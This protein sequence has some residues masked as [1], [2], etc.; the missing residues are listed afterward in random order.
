MRGLEP[1]LERG[2]RATLAR[3]ATVEYVEENRIRRATGASDPKFAQQWSLARVQA[4]AAWKLIPGKFFDST[5]RAGRVRV[6]ILDSGGDSADAAF[7]GQIRFS[8]SRALV[9]TAA[10][11]S[12]CEWNDDSGHGTHVAAIA[13]A[14]ARNGQGIAGAG[15]MDRATATT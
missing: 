1:R 15:Y 13:G 7:G 2:D 11:T 14:A 9:P 6:A 3:R 4:E 10:S 5:P 8:M 12:T